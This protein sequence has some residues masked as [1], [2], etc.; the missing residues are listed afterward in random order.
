M[1]AEESSVIARV[2]DDVRLRCTA[3]G[4]PTPVVRWSK[5]E[6]EM[7]S[8][9]RYEVSIST[10]RNLSELISFLDFTVKGLLICAFHRTQKLRDVH[11]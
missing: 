9:A 8:N 6:E 5:N 4:E 10:C 2:D 3:T 1:V 7:L 11:I